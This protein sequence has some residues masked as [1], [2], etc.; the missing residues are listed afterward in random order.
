MV[1]DLIAKKRIG[2]ALKLKLLVREGSTDTV[3]NKIAQYVLEDLKKV[4]IECNIEKIPADKYFGSIPNSDLFISRW[5]ADTGDPD[6]FLQPNFNK[7]NYTDFSGY[8]NEPVLEM[9]NAAKEIL[10]PL[11]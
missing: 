2:S 10:N 4:G 1:K 7:A 5:I 6:N 8:S 9:M 11:K 3:F